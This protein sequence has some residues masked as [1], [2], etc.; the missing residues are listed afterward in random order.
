MGNDLHP[1]CLLGITHFPKSYSFKESCEL[2][3]STQVLVMCVVLVASCRSDVLFCLLSPPADDEHG[4]WCPAAPAQEDY[5]ERVGERRGAAEEGRER[6]ETWH[7]EGGA[8]RR[9]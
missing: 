7:E 2:D 8:I 6:L 1:V 3:F 5:P 9:P 4:E